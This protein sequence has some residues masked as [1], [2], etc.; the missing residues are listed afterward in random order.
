MSIN[1][2]F[3]GPTNDGEEVRPSEGVVTPPVGVQVG[4]FVDMSLSRTQPSSEMGESLLSIYLSTDITHSYIPLNTKGIRLWSL[5]N[6]Q[7]K[8]STYHPVHYEQ[9]LRTTLDS[10]ESGQG[11]RENRRLKSGCTSISRVSKSVLN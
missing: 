7:T 10:V 1:G 2:S 3:T 11:G 6:L 4:N 9:S 5:S 8:P